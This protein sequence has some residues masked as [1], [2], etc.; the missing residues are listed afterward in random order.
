ML[1]AMEQSAGSIPADFRVT[2]TVTLYRG[3]NLLV[4]DTAS[5]A[6]TP[7]ADPAT[8]A[9]A[10]APAPATTR[11][12]TTAASTTAAA[13]VPASDRTASAEQVLGQMLKPPSRPGTAAGESSGQALRKPETPPETDAN[14]GKGAVQPGAPA[15]TVL[16][17]GT[18]LVDRLGRLT[19]SADGS[20]A[21]FTFESD[22]AALQ[23]PPV[24]IVPNLKLMAMEDAANAINRDL[25]FRITGMVTEYRGRNYVLLE[26]A[27]VV[28]DATQQFR[29]TQE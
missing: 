18:Y 11:P 29:R 10:P 19:R 12:S 2:G 22:G 15:V 28:P 3:R 13:P 8:A 6:G 16:R 4:I 23:D 21:E 1:L 24:V 7:T 27:V 14:S 26:K 17:E 20:T 9:S 25:R 5:P